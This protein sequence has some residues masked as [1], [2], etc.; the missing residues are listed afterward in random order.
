MSGHRSSWAPF[1]TLA[2][3]WIAFAQVLSFQGLAIWVIVGS[4]LTCLAVGGLAR[5]RHVPVAMLLGVLFTAAVPFLASTLGGNSAG[6]IVRASLMA[7]GVSAAMAILLHTR[8]PLTMLAA[9]LMLLGGALGLGAAGQAVWLV[10]LWTVAALLT[11]AMLGAYTR[12][13]LSETR[14]RRAVASTMI[15]VGLAGVAGLLLLG[16]VYGT[17]WTVPGAGPTIAP[18]T[19]TPTVTP[20]VTPTPTPTATPPT[21][22]PPLPTPSRTPPLVTP[23]PVLITPPTPPS[24]TAS[25]LPTRTLAITPAPTPTPTITPTPTPTITPTPT[26]TPTPTPTTTPVVAEKP[27]NPILRLL[28]LIAAGLLALALLVLLAL[29]AWRL[30]VA[31]LWARTRRGLRRGSRGNRIAGAWTWVRLRRA[32][33][34]RPLPVSASPDVAVGVA[35]AAHDTDLARVARLTADVSYNP[36]TVVTDDDVDA[37]WTAARAAGRRPRGASLR[38]R[39]RWSGRRPKTA[40]DLL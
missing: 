15:V 35:E 10:G 12:D 5:A 30:L 23:P 19:A 11:L 9:S 22:V 3:A 40:R 39:W 28:L 29:L 4:T 27:I 2:V 18:P 21:S 25:V 17:P 6:P 14:R 31:A 32:R 7:C 13:D 33:Y 37:A 26:V 36:L 24:A 34:D 1:P 8:T 16:A 20:T 38:E